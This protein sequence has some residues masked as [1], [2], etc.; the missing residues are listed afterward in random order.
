MHSKLSVKEVN[1]RFYG[2]KFLFTVNILL[3]KANKMILGTNDGISNK[4]NTKGFVCKRAD[5]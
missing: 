4:E 5:K 3:T 2:L 1:R